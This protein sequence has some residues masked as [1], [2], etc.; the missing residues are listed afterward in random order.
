[1]TAPMNESGPLNPLTYKY[2][3]K[4]VPNFRDGIN[5][6]QPEERQYLKHL[7]TP[8]AAFLMAKAFGP[9]MGIMLWPFIS[10]DSMDELPDA[11]PADLPDGL[12]DS[13]EA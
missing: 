7:M 11:P 4:F 1:M 2:D 12:P 3:K 10:E 5:R 9:E 8:E 13:L 6:L